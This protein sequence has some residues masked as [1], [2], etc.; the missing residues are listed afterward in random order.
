[1]AVSA[2][3]RCILLVAF[4]SA[5]SCVGPTESAVRTHF[6]PA[7]VLG[8]WEVVRP[9]T[10][11]WKTW[12]LG[13]LDEYLEITDTYGFIILH[14]GRIVYER[15]WRGFT[16]GTAYPWFS[17]GKTL[18][19]Y[20]VGVAIREGRMEL[21]AP[22]SRYLG[23]GW[24]SMTPAQEQA[25]TIRH[26]LSM[27][28]GFD[29][30]HDGL[31]GLNCEAPD[32]FRYL[33]P[34]GTRWAYHNAAYLRLIDALE[35][36]TG[37][38]R[39]VYTRTHIR[40]PLGMGIRAMWS[41]NEGNVFVGTTRDAARWGH[42]ILN[43]G[44]WG[45]RKA[46]VA[47]TYLQAMT[48]PSQSMNPAYG[49]LWWLNGSES[50]MR[51][52]TRDVFSGPIVP[53]APADLIAALGADD[54]KIYVVPSLDLVVVRLGDKGIDGGAALNGYDEEIWKLIMMAVK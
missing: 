11:G 48:R 15:Y 50:H 7:D 26:L 9:E 23:A 45:Q 35:A 44:R 16:A 29:E 47:S 20:L 13:Y 43:Q 6:P 49:Y 22:V 54:K 53:S 37:Q 41:L 51:P 27:T 19:A 30:F 36:A 24:T 34:S 21:D 5:S 39:N 3:F 10:L 8:T 2:P 17:A 32:C 18:T 46:A 52:L 25:V 12:A 31:A 4:L 33:A 1:M 40:D 42:F 14:K 38:T 28:A